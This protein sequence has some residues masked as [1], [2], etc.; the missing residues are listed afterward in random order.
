MIRTRRN[1]IPDNERYARMSRGELVQVD[2]LARQVE[3]RGYS[4]HENNRF[5][6]NKV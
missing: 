5:Q 3:V 1:D 6:E 4:G 2:A